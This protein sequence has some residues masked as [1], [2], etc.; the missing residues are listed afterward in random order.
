[1][2]TLDTTRGTSR[3]AIGRDSTRSILRRAIAKGQVR[4]DLDVDLLIDVIGGATTF[5]LLQGHAPLNP[6]FAQS[7]VALVL[8]GA[9]RR[10]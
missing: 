10:P 6:R 7:L 4:R 3:R 8:L 5:R 9:A 1:M 2:T